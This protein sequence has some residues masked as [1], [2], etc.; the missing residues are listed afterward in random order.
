M[1]ITLIPMIICLFYTILFILN[2]GN[3]IS[4]GYFDTLEAK[5]FKNLH[6]L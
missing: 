5:V 3:V 6:L 2:V 1:N 4:L